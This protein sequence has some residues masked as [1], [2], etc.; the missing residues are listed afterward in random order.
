MAE[1]KT[2]PPDFVAEVHQRLGS[3]LRTD[4]RTRMLYSTD[5]SIY[6]ILPRGVCLPRDADE[7]RGL[8]ELARTHEVPL[9]A[10][11]SGSSLAG[12]AVGDALVLDFSRHCTRILELV[13]EERRVVLEPG[14]VL[15]DLNAA[16]AKHGLMFGPDPASSNRATLGGIVANNASGSH[17]VVYGMT[18]EHLR[19][20]DLVLED[21]SSARLGL[22]REAPA[23][24]G[25]LGRIRSGLS[26]LLA[27]NAEVIRKGTSSHWKRCG[28]Y[29]LDRLLPA[30][31]RPGGDLSQL[32]CGSEG[33]L[34]LITRLELALV[35]RPGATVL[36][37]LTFDDL[38]LALQATGELLTHAPSAVELLDDLSL[39]LCRKVPAYARMLARVVEGSPFCLM[40]VEFCGDTL[41]EAK[42]K[43]EGMLH[44]LGP[45]GQ[46]ESAILDEPSR[47][48]DL[49]AVRKAGL[50]L[51][52]GVAGDHKPIACVED[53]A[54]PVVHLA[55]Y[56]RRLQA[57]CLRLGV[58]MTYYAHAS[59]GC[60]HVR[61][62]IDLKDA[63]GRA[64]MERLA[65]VSA[66]LVGE[67]G[68]A[69]SSEHGD[70]RLRSWLNER[71]FGPELYALFKQ[72]KT[73]FDPRGLFNPGIIVD[74]P[75]M[76][77]QLR[78]HPAYRPVEPE[79]ALAFGSDGFVAAVEQC[80][81]AAVC[82]KRGSGTMCPT[83]MA[84]GEEGHSTRGRANALRNALS[85]TWYPDEPWSD[86]VHELLDTCLSC[87]ACK[88]ECPSAVD[89]AALKTEVLTQRHARR[90]V[91]L[92]SWLFSRLHILGALCSG[93][94]APLVNV[95]LRDRRVRGAL[96]KTLGLAAARPLPR[97]APATFDHV[98]A[99]RVMARGGKIGR[100]GQVVLFADTHVQYHYPEVGLAAVEV[101]EAAGFEVVPSGHTCCGRPSLSKGLVEHARTLATDTVARLYPHAAVGI[102]IVGLEPS[103]L[104]TLRDEYHRLLPGDPRV[105]AVAA[106]AFTFEEFLSTLARED[107]LWLRFER[108][109]VPA[110]LHGHC[111]QKALVGTAPCL[112]TL[113][114]VPGL[115]VRELDT[116]CC[117]LAGSFGYEAEHYELAQKVA[118]ERLYPAL[119]KAPPEAL[120]VAPGTSCR[121]QI[122]HGTGRK[123]LHPAQ[124]LAQALPGR[125][126][127]A[128][129]PHST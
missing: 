1:G 13:P 97:F 4:R 84:T 101:L 44:S 79:T 69:L 36:V 118:E 42:A 47:Q 128:T 9:L 108:R 26:D 28:G 46:R 121:E 30:V 66:E 63:A 129:A 7:V 112:E 50:G 77:E 35:P 25:A 98:F 20:L 49:W 54:V 12:Q 45:L 39:R 55:D 64:A 107:R 88:S 67:Y 117:G 33:T 75:A 37:V 68:G 92:R 111:H 29:A 53:A 110:L 76:T 24:G 2:L 15:D 31:D 38:Y 95:V 114:L 51:L 80:N 14:V 57:C 96:E 61:P 17:G 22:H 100:R 123:A 78:Y 71:F 72:V 94:P 126:P 21:G 10:R 86:E 18:A 73:L 43:A 70:G 11:A 103:C 90:G 65:A 74:A 58:R 23:T 115:E 27:V 6:Q 82:R 8:V 16:A 113:R 5:A 104:L 109:E 122:L 125:T 60:L 99:D 40:V 120:I 116:G 127:R 56:I 106:Q 124:V 102:P 93:W 62:L 34:G 3:D 41:A 105:V 91:P 48:R 89:M 119:R 83:F 59:G 85:G 87:K 19:G 32:V 81:G 52:L